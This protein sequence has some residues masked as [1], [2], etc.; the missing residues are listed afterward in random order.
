VAYT[1]ESDKR[2]RRRPQEN[3]VGGKG[4]RTKVELIHDVLAVQMVSD[5]DGHPWSV[6]WGIGAKMFVSRGILVK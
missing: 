4:R 5:I 3:W 1:K 2:V 6:T